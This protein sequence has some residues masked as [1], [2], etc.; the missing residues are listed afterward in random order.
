MLLFKNSIIASILLW[1]CA[2]TNSTSETITVYQYTDDKG[3]I[4]YTDKAS[5]ESKKLEVLTENIVKISP[6]QNITLGTADTEDH[7]IKLNIKSPQN[8]ETIRNNQGNISIN[9]HT[10]LPIAFD[11]YFQLVIDDFPH[12]APQNLPN[13]ILTNIERGT[14]KI[15]IQLI[16]HQGK[17]I[18]SSPIHTIYMHRTSINSP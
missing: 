12:L 14:H 1:L 9:A 8:N 5:E 11:N 13:F 16:N 17:V 6:S 18:A 7:T 15:K 10:S 2:I 4:T 3:N